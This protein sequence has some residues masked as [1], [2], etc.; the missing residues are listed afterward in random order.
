MIGRL[1][2]GM[3]PGTVKETIYKYVR[4]VYC[5]GG[6]WI[7]QASGD[8]MIDIDHKRRKQIE[9]A[10][11]RGKGLSVLARSICEVD[12]YAKI[13]SPQVDLLLLQMFGG[14]DKSPY[15]M[16]RIR[17]DM[18]I[19]LYDPSPDTLVLA[20][21]I[22]GLAPKWR[23][24]DLGA[25]GGDGAEEPL[26][27]YEGGLGSGILVLDNF[28][29]IRDMDRLRYWLTDL[30]FE[31]H[32]AFRGRT[33]HLLV[34][35]GSTWDGDEPRSA[36]GSLHRGIDIV[37]CEKQD[38][39]TV[40]ERQRAI[41]DIF[42][43]LG[44]SDDI[45]RRLEYYSTDDAYP[46][47]VTPDLVKDYI[48]YARSTYHPRFTRKERETLLQE[49]ESVL[50]A[51][52]REMEVSLL[53]SVIKIS[54]AI[55]RAN[56]RQRVLAEDIQLAVILASWHILNEQAIFSGERALPQEFVQTCEREVV[57]EPDYDPEEAPSAME[58][59]FRPV[60]PRYRLEDI[61]FPKKTRREVEE[62]LCEMRYNQIIYD[63]WGLRKT[64]KHRRGMK[65]LFVG[66]PGTGKSVTAEAIAHE[67]G[68]NMIV[69]SYADL[70]DKYVG[71][72]EKNIVA[73][74]ETARKEN[75]VLIFD[76][77]DAVL[78]QRTVMERSFSNRDVSVLL[79]EMEAFDGVLVLTSNLSALMDTAVRRRIDTI[80][81]F[82]FPDESV[83]ELLWRKK[84]PPDAP[85]SP[86]V[87][88]HTLA[89]RYPLTGGQIENVIRSALRH[90]L[91]RTRDP[92]RTTVLMSDLESSARQ[93]LEKDETMI[94][95]HLART[96]NIRGY[97]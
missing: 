38:I 42:T 97:G 23:Y 43:D 68:M 21:R 50:F 80:I 54:E 79:K 61:V 90:A 25:M 72:T 64:I 76:E 93:E 18:D 10:F 26:S 88:L 13:G 71:E 45:L 62:I 56:L 44:G 86:D 24:I 33:G 31:G 9:E 27:S 35:R 63:R 7:D 48:T 75:C 34:S 14:V 77:A 32:P 89:V 66:Y 73:A 83:R 69:V 39:K 82:E 41:V 37:M 8:R 85:I 3:L 29:P 57:R 87:N 84:M 22:W 47:E 94:R 53:C 65:V 19:L 5:D 51:L 20:S 4:R 81:E 52:D 49:C 1:S 59:M 55:S 30:Q 2:G 78:Y 96:R 12:L 28:V 15:P 17:G 67:L 74:F 40:N 70:E 91:A 6:A 11:G 36:P 46:G 92:D 95:D 58:V 16:M 60:M